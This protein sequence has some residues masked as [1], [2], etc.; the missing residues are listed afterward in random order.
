[1]FLRQYNT[2]EMNSY[3]LQILTLNT[4]LY[5]RITILEQ[6][7][8]LLKTLINIIFTQKIHSQNLQNYLQIV[9]S[10]VS[11]KTLSSSHS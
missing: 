11:F 2:E 8:M 3:H 1:M 10:S 9:K 4:S 6:S 5:K 7:K